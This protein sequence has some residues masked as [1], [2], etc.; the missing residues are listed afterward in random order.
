MKKQPSNRIS[1][2]EEYHFPMRLK[3]LGSLIQEGK[4]FINQGNMHPD[5]ETQTEEESLN[6]I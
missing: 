4:D 6:Y 5:T 3:D 1:T 2:V